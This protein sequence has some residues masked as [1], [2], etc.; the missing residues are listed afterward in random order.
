MVFSK[1]LS[2][3]GVKFTKKH[4][5]CV[6]YTHNEGHNCVLRNPCWAW[7]WKKNQWVVSLHAVVVWSIYALRNLL[8]E[9]SFL[10]LLRGFGRSLIP[11]TTSTSSFTSTKPLLYQIGVHKSHDYSKCSFPK[12]LS[13]A[14]KQMCALTFT[15]PPVSPFS[16]AKTHS[17]KK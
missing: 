4:D 12:A 5:A 6:H 1:P 3:K 17:G 11:F 7:G 13:C 2:R 15:L 8:C 10:P 14:K 9:G 16:I